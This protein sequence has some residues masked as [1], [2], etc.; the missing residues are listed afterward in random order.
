[1][2]FTI[3]LALGSENR[4]V[5]IDPLRLIR[6]QLRRWPDLCQNAAKQ[7]N[8]PRQREKIVFDDA[9]EKVD[10]G[11]PFF[12]GKLNHHPVLTTQIRLLRQIQRMLDP[13]GFGCRA[14]DDDGNV[15]MAPPNDGGLTLASG[16]TPDDAGSR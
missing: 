16:P 11:G 14:D 10:Q 5:I 7:L 8:A 4:W 13:R 2:R 6:R 15:T 1:M 3:L 12:L 9:D